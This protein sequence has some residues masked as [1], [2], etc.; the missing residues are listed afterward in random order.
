[1]PPGSS[2]WLFGHHSQGAFSPIRRTTSPPVDGH[3]WAGAFATR[4]CHEQC[5]SQ[6]TVPFYDDRLHDISMHHQFRDSGKIARVDISQDAD[7]LQDVWMGQRSPENNLPTESLVQ[8]DR[9]T[10]QIG[11][12]HSPSELFPCCS[13]TIFTKPSLP[14]CDSHTLQI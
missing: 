9:Y 5:G 6:L 3:V 13:S 2:D 1:M 4:P 10:F 8:A 11:G 12:R 7:E 14:P